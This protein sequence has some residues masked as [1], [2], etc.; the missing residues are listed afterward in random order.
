MKK[1]KD[2][3]LQLQN[4]KNIRIAFAVQTIGILGILLY[5]AIVDGVQAATDNPLWFVFMITMVV[6]MWLNLRISV[7]VYDDAKEQ[8]KPGSFYRYVIISALV[9]LVIALLAKLGQDSSSNSEA[10]IVGAVVFMAFL[11]PFSF[12]HYL[13]KKRYEDV[14]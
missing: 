3:R 1:V 2:E 11:I 14:E 9:G 13:R 4:L 8:K 7:D 5:E 12:V 6:L 10:F